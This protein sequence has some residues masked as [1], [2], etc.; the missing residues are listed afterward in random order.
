[1]RAV[2]QCLVFLYMFMTS[3]VN[4]A[5]QVDDDTGPV[6]IG[7]PDV[8]PDTP[9]LDPWQPPP[10]PPQQ[11]EPAWDRP[12]PNGYARIDVLNT[13]TYNVFGKGDDCEERGRRM[14]RMVRDSNPG[15]D[16]VGLNEYLDNQPLWFDLWPGTLGCNGEYLLGSLLGG[17]NYP[18]ND[19]HAR[20]HYPKGESFFV[21]CLIIL[22][23]CGTLDPREFE[24]D[25]GV[26]LITHKDYP[27]VQ[28][29]EHEWYADVNFE[30]IRVHGFIFA[31]VQVRANPALYVDVYTVHLYAQSD[32]CNRVC[33]RGSLL[34]LRSA[35][36]KFTGSAPWPVLL[37]GDFNIGGPP[38]ME[39]VPAGWNDIVSV[40]GSPRDVWL[41]PEPQ[42]IETLGAGATYDCANA[43][44]N[45]GTKKK[46]IDFIFLLENIPGVRSVGRQPKYRFGRVEK[47]DRAIQYGGISDHYGVRAHLQVLERTTELCPVEQAAVRTAQTELSKLNR[48]IDGLHATYLKLESLGKGDSAH[49]LALLDQID[50]L[51]AER[52]PLQ[53]AVLDAQEDYGECLGD[54]IIIDSDYSQAC[55]LELHSL[56]LIDASVDELGVSYKQLLSDPGAETDDPDLDLDLDLESIEDA[57]TELRAQRAA[58]LDAFDGCN[59][60]RIVW[61]ERFIEHQPAPVELDISDGLSGDSD[62]PVYAPWP[63]AGQHAGSLKVGL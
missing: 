49:A 54:D 21:D 28:F 22:I 40:F 20:F 50:D 56:Q 36:A 6:V 48:R 32:G 3:G 24:I 57:L 1:M 9:P 37:M 7:V 39:D 61:E 31:R 13:L 59:A 12:V 43:L 46:R 60:D 51:R 44:A 2:A 17:G 11:T 33:R 4:A 8:P 25:G 27:I 19:A 55:E 15:F 5:P 47:E 63:R 18:N 62:R 58:A 29:A 30:N 52:I 10:R 23:G 42:A 35:M 45:C 26:G 16:I 14:G 38:H 53:N 34:Q 41:E